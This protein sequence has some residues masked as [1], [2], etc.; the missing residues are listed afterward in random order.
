MAY[1]SVLITGESASR[2][3][4]I[5]ENTEYE[6]SNQCSNT[7]P[8]TFDFS[9]LSWTLCLPHQSSEHC[10]SSAPDKVCRPVCVEVPS[11]TE[12]VVGNPMK[13][14]CIFCLKREEVSP[15]T[16]VNWFYTPPGGKRVNILYYNE[17]SQKE[18]DRPRELESP[19]KGRLAWNGS[20]DMQELSIRI[21]N[22][23]VNDT[24]TYTCKVFRQFTFDFYSPSVNKTL[25]I[26]LA[27]KEE[28]SEDTTAIYSE[29]MMYVLLVFLTFWLLVEMV[30]CYRKISKSDEQAQDT[31]TNYLAIP[32][33]NKENLGVPV[34]E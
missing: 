4:A 15:I 21:L 20:R 2:A 31:A 12:A 29:I 7:F 25:D 1:I 23:T 24:G 34:M 19:L 13:L 30:Y 10:W 28:A 11:E 14:T 8:I 17:L 18:N 22:V 3:T 6:I 32:S 33:E 27:V 9:R 5:F 26:H 16:I